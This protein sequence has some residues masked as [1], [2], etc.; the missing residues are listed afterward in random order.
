[1]SF[2][3]NLKK[4]SLSEYKEKLKTSDLLKSRKILKENI[5]E[6]FRRI[7]EQKIQ[8]LEDL[9]NALKDKAKLKGFAELSGVSEEYLT[10]LIREIKSHIPNPV[11]IK[12]FPHL[13]KRAAE[14]LE[15]LGI[16]NAMQF[17]NRA[18]TPAMRE[19]L[20]KQT[21]IT[22][23]EILR[24]TR[25]S[26]LSR[27]R[28]VNHTFAYILMEASYDAAI[29]T[30]KADYKKLYN[31]VKTLNEKRKI[32]KGNIGLHDMKLCVEAAKDLDMDVEY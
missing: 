25:L 12:D 5:D 30:A 19:E 22:E 18:L 2:Y 28:W 4:I 9:L 10:I 7:S 17:Y 29:K 13:E 20:V 14:K 23:K 21:G 11:K 8:N 15:K 26:D 32:F 31:D 16:K 6:I 1:M 3:I 27:I 24:L